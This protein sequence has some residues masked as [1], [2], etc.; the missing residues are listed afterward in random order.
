MRQLSY[1]PCV[2]L[3]FSAGESEAPGG[4]V[5]DC[6]APSERRFGRAIGDPRAGSIDRNGDGPTRSWQG[7]GAM[8]AASPMRHLMPRQ[9][10][11]GATPN[12]CRSV[13]PAADIETDRAVTLAAPSASL[14]QTSVSP[15]RVQRSCDEAGDVVIGT[16]AGRP[17]HLARQAPEVGEAG[18]DFVPA[19]G[20]DVD[21]PVR[22]R[23]RAG[24][25]ASEVVVGE[26][27]D[28]VADVGLPGQTTG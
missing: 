5:R 20:G 19:V 18:A 27:R 22:P 1:S 15:G 11:G 26:G 28:G 10:E 13:R 3:V 7:A 25:Q 17:V 4:E 8:S 2:L 6:V 23:H 12:G 16:D 14:P 9:V 21:R 24:R